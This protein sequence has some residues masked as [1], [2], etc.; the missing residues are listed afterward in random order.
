MLA[1]SGR[2]SGQNDRWTV[3]ESLSLLPGLTMPG[4]A[5]AGTFSLPAFV[6]FVVKKIGYFW[7]RDQ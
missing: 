1:K 3:G 4:V 7:L 6:G 2:Y 5:L